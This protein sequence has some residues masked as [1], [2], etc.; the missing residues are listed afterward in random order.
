LTNVN[1]LASRYPAQVR[2]L[3]VMVVLA[4]VALLL[5]LAAP[6][7]TLQK[8]VLIENTFSIVSGAGQLWLDGRWFLF[9]IV[10]GFSIVLPA[11]K[12]YILHRLLGRRCHDMLRLRRYLHWMHR[13]GRWSMLDVFVVAVLIVAVKLGAVAQ[14]E[15]RYGLYAFATSVLLTMVVT[16]RVV[17]LA[18][19]L[20]MRPGAPAGEG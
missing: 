8:F 9:L 5:G 12:L 16:A 11:I 13:Y 18:E 20:D 4:A 17:A 15:M 1:P 2:L 7:I 6:I 14:V 19:R 10:T 3:Q